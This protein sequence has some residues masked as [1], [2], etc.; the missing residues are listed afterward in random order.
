VV[1]HADPRIRL[2]ILAS[3]P[4]DAVPL[5]GSRVWLSLV[6][7]VDHDN[8]R[9]RDIAGLK[10]E[11]AAAQQREAVTTEVATLTRPRDEAFQ[12]VAWYGF[13]REQVDHVKAHPTIPSGRSTLSGR[14]M[15]EGKVIHIPDIQ[16]DLEH[17]LDPKVRKLD[18]LISVRTML[19]VPLI[20]EGAP[21][22]VFALQRKTVRPFTDKQI[23]LVTTFADQAVIAIENARLF[24]E[25]QARTRE[26]TEALE[27]QTATSEVLQV[28]SSSPGELQPVF[29]KMLEN[30]T[31][32][33]DAEFG[34]MHLRADDGLVRHVALHN[35][36]AAFA[37]HVKRDPV[38]RNMSGSALERLIQAKQPFHLEDLRLG[39]GY[40]AGNKDVRNFADLTGARTVAF[41]P[42]I[43]DGEVIGSLGIYRCEVR[44]FAD[45]QVELLGNFAR[46]AVIAIENTRLL[47]ELRQRTADL[48]ES[49][50]QQTATS[51]VL[52]VISSSPSE[53]D[54]VFSTMLENATR[55]CAAE[56]GI[57][58]LCENGG[59]RHVALCNT[60]PAFMEM[61]RQ[62]PVLTPLIGGPLDR[63]LRTKQVVHVADMREESIYQTGAPLVSAF[64]DMAG[65]RTVLAVPMLKEDK[66]VGGIT[67]FRQE[68]RPFSDKQIDLLH[69]F[70][71][72]AVIAIENARLLNELRESLEQQTATSEVLQVIGS[73][74]GE[75]EPVFNRCWKTRRAFVKLSSALYLTTTVACSTPPQCA[76]RRRLCSNS[77]SNADHSSRHPEPRWTAF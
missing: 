4:L 25:V 75:L 10:A 51:E 42:M 21:I 13:S 47:N 73:S 31:R 37:E 74:P 18:A 15:L 12:L 34:I 28:I 59:L 17:T 69:N 11:L 60:P 48:T 22:G 41:V 27:Q 52:K 24:D 45:K 29:E 43:K 54:V 16:A 8:D 40:L 32:V 7:L 65:A 55:V 5:V 72:Q 14:T 33:C 35:V 23:E 44:R 9:G 6:G 71:S 20:R 66:I 26:L 61:V 77:T 56:F 76:T 49:L 38:I 62:N 70:A 50:D 30:A 64:V 68:V 67:I 1:C 3:A 63:M 57:L 46:Q 39:P 19:G 2:R 36:P 53:L 58:V